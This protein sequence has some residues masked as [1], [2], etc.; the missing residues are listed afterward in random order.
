[1]EMRQVATCSKQKMGGHGGA[2]RR[3]ALGALALV[4]AAILPAKRSHAMK[5][6]DAWCYRRVGERDTKMEC[7]KEGPLTGTIPAALGDY[8]AL[9]RLDLN[10]N[11]LTG[12]I[13]PA[14]GKLPVRTSRITT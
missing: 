13:P 14:L 10:N 11:E 2:A 9:T 5:L 3:A 7:E 8:L 4:L 1:M 12:A 6:E